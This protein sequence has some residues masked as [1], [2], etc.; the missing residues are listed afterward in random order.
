[1]MPLRKANKTHNKMIPEKGKYYRCNKTVN[2]GDAVVF[3]ADNIYLSKKDSNLVG[4]DGFHKVVSTD[5]YYWQDFEEVTPDVVD[6]Y[7]RQGKVHEGLVN[8]PMHY[9][10]NNPKIYV[11]TD[12]GLLKEV[13]IECIDVIRDMPSWKGNIIKYTWRAGLKEEAGKSIIDKE[14]EDLEKIKA[15]ANDRINQ[16]KLK[17]QYYGL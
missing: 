1:M 9:N 6:T 8:H 16:L 2:D 5:E 15:Y 11:K 12:T 13:T 14:I 3:K 17:Q 7:R 10:T 4:E